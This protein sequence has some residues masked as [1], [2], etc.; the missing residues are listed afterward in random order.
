MMNKPSSTIFE[1][2]MNKNLD[3]RKCDCGKGSLLPSVDARLAGL[4]SRLLT[5]IT[6]STRLKTKS[7]RALFYLPISV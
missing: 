4:T 5:Q 3:P 2:G 1:G 7:L 6:T